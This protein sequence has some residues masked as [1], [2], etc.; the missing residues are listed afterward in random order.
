[1]KSLPLH[2]EQYKY[3]EQSFKQWLDVLGYAGTTVYGM[4]NYIREFF[5]WLEQHGIKQVNDITA[6]HIKQYYAYIKQRI[7]TKQGGALSPSYINKH[8]QALSTFS[9]YIR[10]AGR[11]QMP[12]VKLDGL[13]PDKEKTNVLTPSEIK[14]LYE[15]SHI[16][17]G[18]NWDNEIAIRD[19]AILSVVYGCGLR[20]NEAT[21]LNINDID[22][23]KNIVHVRKGKGN[24]ERLVP[25]NKGNIKYIEEYI[26]NARPVFTK[27]SKTE[28]FFVSIRTGRT[29]SMTIS[30]RL[31]VLVQKTK[32]VTLIEKAPTLHTLRHSIATH[33]LNNGMKLEAISKFLGHS[34]LES[35]QI[36]THLAEEQEAINSYQ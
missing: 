18:S 28:A 31:N 23:E 2:N 19:R 14:Q 13:K 26:Y 9:E 7:N 12:Y 17:D 6:Q 29:N 32:N 10:Q 24:K 21:Q 11:Y 3:V 25:L 36:Y 22:I 27:G 8:R 30:R 35:T 34:S 5:N 4:P 20:R 16:A 1:M 33:L 15:A